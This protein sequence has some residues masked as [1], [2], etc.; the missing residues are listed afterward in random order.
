MKQKGF[1]LVV[2]LIFMAMMSLLAIYMFSGFT[3]D[4]VLSAN[5]R[6]KSRSLDATQSA[7]DY[8]LLWL[9]TSGNTNNGT[10]TGGA[11]T[12]TGTTPCIFTQTALPIT[13]VANDPS[14]WTVYTTFTPTG[15]SVVSGG[16]SANTYNTKPSY[17]MQYVG[18]GIG[19]NAGAALYQ[20]TASAQGGNLTATSVAQA[21]YAVKPLSTNL[22]CPPSC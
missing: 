18:A 9:G 12:G 19:A 14:T 10:S 6:E 17:Y 20:V 21:V 1:I 13:T 16:G 22:A 2:S 3:T 7:L 8:A 4:A 5:S 15:M 11:C